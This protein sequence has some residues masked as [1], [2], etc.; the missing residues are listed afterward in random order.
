MLFHKIILSSI[1][2]RLGLYSPMLIAVAISL[3]LIGAASLVSSNFN[4]ILN[5]EMKK[6]GANV[7]VK[8]K[9]KIP[10]NG[11]HVALQVN[12]TVIGNR[13][14]SMASGSIKNL[15]QINPAW[16]AK[17]APSIMV[18]NQVAGELNLKQGQTIEMH[19]VVGEV[20]VFESGTDFDSF[21]FI[22]KKAVE[23]NMYMVRTDHPE[24]YRS[25]NAVIMEEM[26]R[27]KYAVL[28]SIKKLMFFI[29]LISVVASI[30]TV[31]NLCRVDAASRRKEFGIFKSLGASMFS[32]WK[33][34]SFEFSI[35]AL[36]AFVAGLAGSVL[37]SWLVLYY[38]AGASLT[39]NLQ[40][41][42][43]IAVTS[44]VS[45]SFAALIFIIESKR[46][47]VMEELRNE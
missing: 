45:F 3:C 10:I 35:L 2:Y 5:R 14:I 17:G 36:V 23:P 7:I 43:V 44:L 12:D 32:I 26:V 25:M 29:A 22:D 27:T 18:G 13:K 30:T 31:I 33:L 47:H 24:Q 37:L 40:S 19:G 4:H 42:V 20:S 16:T 21:I 8:T 41:V 39:M 28:S 46:V 9:G 15:L 34:L 1:K 11:Q 6:Y 38:A